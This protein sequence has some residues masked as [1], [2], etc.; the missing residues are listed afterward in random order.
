M[1]F[2]VRCLIVVLPLILI[3]LPKQMTADIVP[4]PMARGRALQQQEAEHNL[5]RPAAVYG[6]IE[7]TV[8][9]SA[10]NQPIPYCN[11]CLFGTGMGSLVEIDGSFSILDVPTGNYAVLV[12]MMRYVADTL[13]QVE[14]EDGK[15]I[16]LS[17]ELEPAEPD[18]IPIIID[19]SDWLCEIHNVPI[20]QVRVSIASKPI[21]HD[22]AYVKARRMLFPHGEIEIYD[23]C[24]SQSLDSMLVSR[25]PECIKTREWW[26]NNRKEE[27]D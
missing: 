5:E 10:T 14:V 11:V 19:D 26:L 20:V 4:D 24:L 25:C 1:R 3:A 27:K 8:F 17:F 7:G 6:S 15:T 16:F 2:H 9:D 12:A 22:E 21:V 23:E 13:C 18:T